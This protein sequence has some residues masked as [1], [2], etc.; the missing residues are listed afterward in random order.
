MAKFFN[1]K[2]INGITTCLE[3][4]MASFD[5]Y[6]SSTWHQLCIKYVFVINYAHSAMGKVKRKKRQLSSED[7]AVKTAEPLG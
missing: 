7:G 5:V 4:Y 6:L 1:S 2:L 3:P